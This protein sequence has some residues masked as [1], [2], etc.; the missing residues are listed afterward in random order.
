MAALSDMF[1]SKPLMA[2]WSVS[3][4]ASMSLALAPNSF[5]APAT[6][7]PARIGRRTCENAV[8]SFWRQLM[9]QLL[10][11]RTRLAKG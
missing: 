5:C 9:P 2:P 11:W 3:A 10:Y 7:M 1:R 6:L 8:P 4:A